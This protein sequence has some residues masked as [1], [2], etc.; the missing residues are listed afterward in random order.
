MDDP[1]TTAQFVLEL[2][3]A[4]DIQK[5][6]ETQ[7]PVL[8]THSHS[9][10]IRFR[11]PIADWAVTNSSFRL[12]PERII[13][14]LPLLTPDLDH[15]HPDLMPSH[16]LLLRASSL[17]GNDLLF[18]YLL[19]HWPPSLP[20]DWTTP[21]QGDPDQRHFI[22]VALMGGSLPI[23]QRIIREMRGTVNGT[24]LIS[25]LSSSATH[26]LIQHAA[27]APNATSIQFL[28]DN[29]IPFD[30]TLPDADG[31]TPLLRAAFC[32]NTSGVR[33]LLDHYSSTGV[34]SDFGSHQGWFARTSRH[35][36]LLHLAV[37]SNNPELVEMILDHPL[38]SALMPHQKT[39]FLTDRTSGD[40]SAFDMS[41]QHGNALI[42]QKLLH[43][44]IASSAQSG[45]TRLDLSGIDL[46]SL[47]KEMVDLLPDLS[48]V[49]ELDLT[50]T[51]I[52]T[53][54][55]LALLS[56]TSAKK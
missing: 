10:L 3:S 43:T 5:L 32:G 20:L 25:T 31:F 35:Q 39:D 12:H 49:T 45:S 50:G 42:F 23:L 34:V 41:T 8:E 47:T 38:F 44:F 17:A 56:K 6:W 37:H 26:S 19:D 33:I 15:N 16:T 51:T 9:D 27:V 48:H 22:H 30:F 14:L 13:A 4:Q 24:E 55:R 29:Q 2:V 54:A 28:I 1:I 11:G 52:S 36:T 46:S 7:P 21:I 53:E 18:S 40:F